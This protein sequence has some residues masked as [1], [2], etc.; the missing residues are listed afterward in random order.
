MNEKEFIFM[1]YETVSNEPLTAAVCSFGAI[2]GRWEDVN[3]DDIHATIE[4]LRESAF[5]QT[6]RVKEQIAEYGLS[7]SK[8]TLDWWDQQGEFAKAMLHAKDKVGIVEHCTG[9]FKWC[10]ENGVTQKT[11]VWVRAPHFDHTIL[12][13]VHRV[14]GNP[15]PY[16][17]WK[18]RDVRTAIDMV[19]N[20]ENGYIPGFRETLGEYN[21]TE[22]FAV[23][24][25]IKDILQIAMCRKVANG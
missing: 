6:I 14:T 20:V 12:A 7:A 4:K 22:H 5:Y 23:D 1:D 9:F 11:I 17:T 3:L 15:I 21:L 19:F 10:S 2:A 16:N 24:D 13:N 25:C 18:V 8:S